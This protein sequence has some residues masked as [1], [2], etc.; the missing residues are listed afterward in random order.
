M[1][2]T[3]IKSRPDEDICLMLNFEN[4]AYNYLC[5]CGMASDLSVKDCRDTAAIFVSHTHI[6]HFIN[7]D[8]IMRHQLAIGRRVVIC[9]PKGIGRNVQAKMLSFS[10]DLLAYD[11]KAVSYEVREIDDNG[12][13]DIYLLETPKWELKHLE[14]LE[15]P[16]FI[17]QNE[18][19][20]VRFTLL[21]HGINT[22]AYLFEEQAKIKIDNSK[23]PFRAGKWIQTLKT[24]FADNTP[25]IDIVI[26]ADNSQKAGDL[27]YLLELQRGFRTA[28]VIDHAATESNFDKIRTLCQDADELYIESYYGMAERDMAEKN[29]HSVAAFSGKVAREANVKKAVP[30][31]FS[32]RYHEE[33]Q[34][35][36]LLKE[37]YTAF[38]VGG[39]K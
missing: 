6:D 35:A 34:R 36:E 13:V 1:I 16:E 12:N 24:A 21:Y 10:W 5:D 7:F 3:T 33:E 25:D 27:F 30:V 14:R 23:L 4:H 29:K 17:Y 26:D 15:N 39:S 20:F 2:Q 31:H 9:G 19:F 38:G 11:D 8:G 37:F 22:V 28:Y 32:R 18:L